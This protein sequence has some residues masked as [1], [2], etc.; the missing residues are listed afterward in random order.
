M[1]PVSFSDVEKTNTLM[2]SQDVFCEVHL[3]NN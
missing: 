1:T 3:I 2:V